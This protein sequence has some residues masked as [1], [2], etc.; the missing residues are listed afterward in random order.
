VS[1]DEALQ[2]GVISS[3]HDNEFMNKNESIKEVSIKV[4]LA[5]MHLRLSEAAIPAT[6]APLLAQR[7]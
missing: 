3:R 5:A 2:G 6:A 4:L 7:P 1:F